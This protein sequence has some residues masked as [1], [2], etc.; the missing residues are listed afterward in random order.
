MAGEVGFLDTCFS[1][2]EVSDFLSG[3][4]A[5]GISLFLLMEQS[6]GG[7]GWKGAVDSCAGGYCSMGALILS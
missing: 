1:E 3:R 5:A 7:K 4:I 6:E 2:A